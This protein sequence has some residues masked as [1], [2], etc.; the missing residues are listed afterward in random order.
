MGPEG[1]VVLARLKMFALLNTCRVVTVDVVTDVRVLV[2]AA[3]VIVFVTVVVE[4]L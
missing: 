3:T 1:S 2:E 4:V